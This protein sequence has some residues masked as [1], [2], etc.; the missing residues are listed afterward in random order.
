VNGCKNYSQSVY[1]WISCLAI[2]I[3]GTPPFDSTGLCQE[4]AKEPVQ[5]VDSVE[6]Y[7]PSAFAPLSALEDE[8]LPAAPHPPISEIPPMPKPPDDW[9]ENSLKSMKAEEA[10]TGISYD[11]TTGET[12]LTPVDTE[13]LMDVD[14]KT[15]GGGYCGPEGCS[16]KDNLLLPAS[17]GKMSKISSTGSDPWRRNVKLLMRFGDSW[18]VCSGTMRDAEVV[19]TAGHC[20]YNYGGSGWADEVYSRSTIN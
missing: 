15:Y 14:G 17:F 19:L 11:L 13:A 18:Y 3:S 5:S 20:V 8:P 12:A 1:N 9:N 4:M 16:H 10:D 7:H 2:F 6:T